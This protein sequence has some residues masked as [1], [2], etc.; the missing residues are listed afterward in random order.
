MRRWRRMEKISWNDYVRNEEA[1]L[2]VK[3]RGNILHEISKR[4]VTFCVETALYKRLLKKRK[5]E[6][7][8]V[9]ER[10]ERRRKKLLDDLKERTV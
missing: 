8:E 9:S 5:K 10:R 3:E 7:I 1:L 6:G 4:L 2:K